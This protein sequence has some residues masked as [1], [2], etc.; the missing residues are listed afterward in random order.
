MMIVLLITLYLFCFVKARRSIIDIHTR[1]WQPRLSK[2]FIGELAGQCVGY[3]GAD[4]RAL[5]TEAA[6]VALRRRYPQIYGTN[7]KLVLDTEKIKITVKDFQYAM[8]KVVPA[9]Q[10]SVAA[11]G[12]ALHRVMKPLLA[13]TLEL[14]LER[15]RHSF[16]PANTVHGI[17][18]Y[19]SILLY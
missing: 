13:S 15:I 18:A 7:K 3:C 11:P 4:I 2:N 1:E 12:R 19:F 16:P 8:K 17:L 9:S 5:C 14:V 6:L 10:R